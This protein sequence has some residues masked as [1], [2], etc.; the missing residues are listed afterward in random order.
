ME[1]Y[2]TYLYFDIGGTPIY[3]GK[4]KNNRAFS[5]LRPSTKT[6]LGY[7][8]RKRLRQGCII[9]PTIHIEVDEKTALNMERFWISFYG[10]KDLK[11]GTLFNLTD[12]GDGSTRCSPLKGIK[13]G[14]NK[15]KGRKG[16]HTAEHIKNAK[17]ARKGKGTG[18]NG[19]KGIKTGKSSWNSGKKLGPLTDVIKAKISKKLKGKKIGKREKPSAPR[20]KVICP[21]CQLEGYLCNMVKT[22]F[23]NCTLR[24]DGRLHPKSHVVKTTC[25]CCKRVV[26][27]AANFSR[28]HGE[29]CKFG[30]CNIKEHKV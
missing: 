1:K 24:P 5:H 20:E 30:D 6:H 7:L 4:G 17:L 9:K 11:E 15:K 18:P 21:H 19:R 13:T 26:S 2:Y 28:W 3:V 16:P 22:H 14:P 25:L 8:L 23:D 12:G 10:R 27:G 29:N